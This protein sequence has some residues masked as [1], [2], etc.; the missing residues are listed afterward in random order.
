M[1]S[2]SLQ[3]KA[4]LFW[5]TAG[6]WALLAWRALNQAGL[7]V[8]PVSASQIAGGALDQAELLMVPGGW[9]ALKKAALGSGGAE[10][11]RKFVGG[12]GFYL[13]LCG[14]AGL[15]LSVA[16]G[17]NLLPLG[18]YSGKR[19]LTAI[20][21]PVLVE[22]SPESLA[23]PWWQGLRPPA[24]FQVWWPGQFA[25]LKGDEVRMLAFYAGAAPG[26]CTSDMQADQVPPD[27]WPGLEDAYGC[28]LNPQRLIGLPAIVQGGYGK[29]RVFISYLH[30]DTPGDENGRRV[31]HN[32]WQEVLGDGAFQDAPHKPEAPGGDSSEIV[33]K[34]DRMWRL[35]QELRLWRG[36]GPDSVFPLW[37]RGSRG[38]E[39][40]SLLMLTR[41]AAREG[42]DPQ[43]LKDLMQPILDQAPKVLQAQAAI[44]DRKNPDAR[45]KKLHS[46]W[47]PRP[48]RT[49]GILAQTLSRLENLLF[50]ELLSARAH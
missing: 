16:D 26:L 30:F 28:Y 25:V 15:S 44:L 11:V 8:E 39:F 3:K 42:I 7:K 18:R 5:E 40:F 20:S 19:R 31:L 37:R 24:R 36:R 4:Y 9:P 23:L 41:A 27:E 21:G 14:G 45:E 43:R 12:G 33:G 29:G 13:G 17:L 35:G 1:P 46:D 32:L 50:K 2:D 48:R 49:G 38:L 6:I 34:I 22:P 10:A 47:F